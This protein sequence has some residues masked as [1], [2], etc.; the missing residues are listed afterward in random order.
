LETDGTEYDGHGFHQV[1]EVKGIV[2]GSE[3]VVTMHDYPS[4]LFEGFK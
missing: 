2:I 4:V 3:H 1:V